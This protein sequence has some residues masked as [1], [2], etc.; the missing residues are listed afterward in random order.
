MVSVFPDGNL[1]IVATGSLSMDILSGFLMDEPSFLGK[2]GGLLTPFSNL[3]INIPA[4]HG[5]V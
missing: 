3:A 2:T 1:L 4:A 5:T